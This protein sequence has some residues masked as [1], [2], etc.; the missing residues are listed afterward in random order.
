MFEFKS[1]NY[2]NMVAQNLPMLQ[3]NADFASSNI[4]VRETRY[5]DLT[6]DSVYVKGD[7]MNV[8]TCQ[9]DETKRFL[10]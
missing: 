2:K 6:T 9:S 3:A 5:G 7:S 10:Q 1:K 8:I 4:M